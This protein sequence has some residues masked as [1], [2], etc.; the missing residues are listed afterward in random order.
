M[1]YYDHIISKIKRNKLLAILMLIG[2]TIISLGDLKEA[3]S[4][5]TRYFAS[6]EDVILQ[7]VDQNNSGV[8]NVRSEFENGESY[9]S[10]RQG[11]IKIEDRNLLT[12]EQK[13][14]L[15][16]IDFLENEIILDLSDN[17]LDTV[18]M[19]ERS[20][21]EHN[22][23]MDKL[24]SLLLSKDSRLLRIDTI[25]NHSYY[26][27]ANYDY[28]IHVIRKTIGTE[29]YQY[30]RSTGSSM[31]GNERYYFNYRTEDSIYFI[32]GFS[33][34]GLRGASVT[35]DFHDYPDFS[36]KV[37]IE[38]GIDSLNNII[39]REPNHMPDL[40]MEEFVINLGYRYFEHYLTF[41]YESQTPKS[42]SLI[43]I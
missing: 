14:Y 42:L 31:S 40:Q 1:T 34:A 30:Y 38:L 6:N 7:I 18:I 8:H 27:V 5:L 19:V 3:L 28:D 35:F 25:N 24:S 11:I 36:K 22:I 2:V 16:H 15:S 26:F 37:E 12:A 20:F 29:N 21:S 10:D 32:Q 17:D 13:V 9:I 39:V 33:E 43:H 41:N 4:E 23:L